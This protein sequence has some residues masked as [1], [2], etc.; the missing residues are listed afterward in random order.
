[1]VLQRIFAAA[2][3]LVCAGLT[4]MAWPY[5]APFSYEP[6][7][8]RAFPLLMLGLMGLALLY[9][10]FRPT[11]IVHSE[12]EPPLD[13]ETLIKIGICIALLLVFAGLFEP[14]GFILS[15]ILIGVPMA[16][17]YG[18]RWVPS[19]VV[20]TLMSVGLYLLFDKT[21]DVPL[22]LG[23]LSVLEN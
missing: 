14:L 12:D 19:I 1:M 2:L 10:L 3:L 17:L 22:P 21:M 6:V 5:Q 13:R 4:L 20:V 16:R 23:L 8:P 7:G 11:P 18:G 15:S 9:L